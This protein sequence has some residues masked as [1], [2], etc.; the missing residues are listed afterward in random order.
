MR[1]LVEGEPRLLLPHHLPLGCR[2]P[3]VEVEESVPGGEE[4]GGRQEGGQEGEG[5][6]GAATRHRPLHHTSCPQ[7]APCLATHLDPRH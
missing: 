7:P 5:R 6:G 2:W 4:Q 1:P 3:P